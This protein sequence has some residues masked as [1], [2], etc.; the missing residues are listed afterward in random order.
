VCN[1]DGLNHRQ[2]ARNIANIAQWVFVGG[3]VVAAGGI[4]LFVTAP[5]GYE[6]PP[7]AALT[8]SPTLG[9]AMLQG[10]W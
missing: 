10:S 4:V 1:Q 2:D 6:Q 3:A 8:L 5:S 9:G 7:R